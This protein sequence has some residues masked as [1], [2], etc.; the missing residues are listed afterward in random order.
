MTKNP[1]CSLL[2]TDIKANEILPS[3]IYN[4]NESGCFGKTL[5][6]SAVG[7]KNGTNENGSN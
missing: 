2:L 6:C 4:A 1:L 3:Q 5:V 7:R